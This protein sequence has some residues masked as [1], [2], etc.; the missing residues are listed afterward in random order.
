MIHLF[1]NLPTYVPPGYR[2]A[3][4]SPTETICT[5]TRAEARAL[6]RTM[7]GAARAVER[8]EHWRPGCWVHQGE[9][10]TCIDGE[11]AP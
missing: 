5:K 3:A 9:A 10:T 1:A 2:W 4:H 7:I 6:T 8:R 11:A